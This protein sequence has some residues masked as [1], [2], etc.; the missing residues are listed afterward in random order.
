MTPALFLTLAALLAVTTLLSALSMSL[1]LASQFAIDQASAARGDP[2]FGAWLRERR[3]GTQH[4]VALLRTVG[5]LSCVMVVLLMVHDDSSGPSPL[6]WSD[7]ALALAIASVAVWLTTSVVAAAI[8]RHR[9][10]ALVVASIAL[11]K[12]IYF[13]TRPLLWIGEGIDAAARRVM[14]ALPTPDEAEQELL[15]TIEDSARAGGL[16]SHAAQIMRNA[17]EFRD[18]VAS[19]VMTPRTQV[20]GLE[21]TDD[22]AMVRALIGRVG[23]SRIP[24]Y[25]G[26]LDETVGILY[27]KD[28]MKY[29]GAGSEGF[30]LAPLL[31]HP[32]RVPETK[33]VSDLLRD[34]QHSEVHMAVVVDEFGGT[35]G[36]VTIED[37]LEEIV[38]EIYDEHEP[39][40][41]ATPSVVATGAG[42]WTVDGGVPLSELADATGLELPIDA[43]FDTAAGIALSHFG[44]VP[45]QGERFFAFGAHFTVDT[46]SLTRV[47]RMKIEVAQPNSSPRKVD[48]R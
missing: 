28:L 35:A 5:R 8:A 43:D 48:A 13:A 2:A 40:S 25:R 45:T 4:A 29:L 44:R 33:R 26:S 15:H 46:A 9:A 22:L 21:Y 34:F 39:A 24:V 41:D 11:L 3:D 20:E 47:A 38:G 17:V 27:V 37:V 36:L 14:G 10:A 18:T 31:R 23:H 16:D 6:Q 42:C 1:V 30:Q 19:E 12:A 7:L 32:L